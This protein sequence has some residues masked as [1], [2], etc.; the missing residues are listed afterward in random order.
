MRKFPIISPNCVSHFY[1]W[2]TGVPEQYATRVL[3]LLKKLY[4]FKFKKFP[5]FQW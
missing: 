5:N 3:Q 4:P 2:Y 1:V